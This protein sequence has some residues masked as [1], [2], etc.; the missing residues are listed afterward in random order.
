MNVILR[1]RNNW[2]SK[3]GY[4]LEDEI[5][6][7]DENLNEVYLNIQ[8]ILE[9]LENLNEYRV[10]WKDYRYKTPTIPYKYVK[11]KGL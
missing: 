11:P 4:T 5:E 10:R 7:Y 9:N 1:N 3:A 8:W 6:I 2:L